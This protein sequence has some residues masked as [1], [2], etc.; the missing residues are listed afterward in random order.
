MELKAHFDSASAIFASA[1]S[2]SFLASFPLKQDKVKNISS[3]SHRR[4]EDERKSSPSSRP[5]HRN[6]FL[7]LHL[8]PHLIPL[9]LRN[10]STDLIHVV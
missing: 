9:D 5:S 7:I 2:S 4:R 10:H 8:I 1:L 6:P 3:S